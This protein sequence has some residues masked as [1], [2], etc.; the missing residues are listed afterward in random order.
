MTI[1]YDTIKNELEQVSST[2]ELVSKISATLEL[3]SI[4]T[5]LASTGKAKK[6]LP[7]AQVLQDIHTTLKASVDTLATKVTDGDKTLEEAYLLLDLYNRCLA[8]KR[9][10]ESYLDLLYP[11]KEKNFVKELSNVEQEAKNTANSLKILASIG[12]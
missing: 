12:E 1:A 3:D 10:L 4:F 5:G 6:L 8:N 9:D 7:D 2:S 11:F